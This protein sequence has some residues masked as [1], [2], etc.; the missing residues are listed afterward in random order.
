[1]GK[2]RPIH[3]TGFV[4]HLLHLTGQQGVFGP[5]EKRVFSQKGRSLALGRVEGTSVVHQ[6]GNLQGRQD[7]YKRQAR[8]RYDS[9]R[10][11]TQL[12]KNGV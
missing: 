4:E 2:I 11:K 3:C 7:V 12:K 1:M 10:Y 5:L 8:N 6:I 9:A